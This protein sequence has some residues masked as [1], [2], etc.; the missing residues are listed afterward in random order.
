MNTNETINYPVINRIIGEE[1]TQVTMSNDMYDMLVKLANIGYY[2]LEYNK[3]ADL[4]A[5]GT[6]RTLST[7]DMQKQ[8]YP[9]MRSML[10]FAS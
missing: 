3:A 7:Q 6:G 2:S 1:T 4:F 5:T 9:L 10:E 8:A